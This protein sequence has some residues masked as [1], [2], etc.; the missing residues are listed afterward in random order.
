MARKSKSIR[1]R[2]K[3]GLSKLFASI[4]EGD[5]VTLVRNLSF[6][7]DFPDRFQG[8]TGTVMGKRG[9]SLIV[10][11]YDGKK[12]KTLVVKRINLKKL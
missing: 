5:K 2:G 9:V 6:S 8:K 12:P 11:I 4:N 3:L 1:E 10:K 7:K